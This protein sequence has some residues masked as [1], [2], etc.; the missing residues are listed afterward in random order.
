MKLSPS[1]VSDYTKSRLCCQISHLLLQY[2][3]SVKMLTYLTRKLPSVNM[4]PTGSIRLYNNLRLGQAWVSGP[5][6]ML[7]FGSGL[8]D[9]TCM[10]FWLMQ[11][12][13][14]TENTFDSKLVRLK[15]HQIGQ[16]T[17][18]ISDSL[19]IMFLYAVVSEY[20]TQYDCLELPVEIRRFGMLNLIPKH[21]W[22]EHFNWCMM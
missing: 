5:F 2:M 3:I 17:Q 20:F 4:V 11:M 21:V 9:R 14:W 1:K 16:R 10:D 13:M 6:R 8:C 7:L 19:S 18:K 22:T 15:F 12:E